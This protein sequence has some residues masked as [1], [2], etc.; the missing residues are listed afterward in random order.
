MNELNGNE[1][2]FYLD[3]ELPTNEINPKH[4]N[5]GDVIGTVGESAMNEIAEEPHLLYIF[6]AVAGPK[7]WRQN[8]ITFR[9]P[10]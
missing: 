7:Y 2:Y 1:K 3:T 8:A 9:M 6:T 4:I 5:K 10:N